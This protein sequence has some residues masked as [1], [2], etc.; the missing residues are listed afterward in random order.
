MPVYYNTFNDDADDGTTPIAN[1]DGDAN[2]ADPSAVY[3]RRTTGQ[4][5]RSILNPHALDV[6][7]DRQSTDAYRSEG[8][9]TT[10]SPDTRVPSTTDGTATV[11]VVRRATSEDISRGDI[12]NAVYPTDKSARDWLLNNNL[13]LTDELPANDGTADN[14]HPELVW[15]YD[16]NDLFIDSTLTEGREGRTVNIGTFETLVRKTGSVEVIAYNVDGVSIFR[17]HP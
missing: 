15:Q 14:D 3:P 10:A 12:R 4:T 16:D 9:Y 5:L 6:Y 7:I 13:L 2:N 17:V 8:E 11:W 1:D